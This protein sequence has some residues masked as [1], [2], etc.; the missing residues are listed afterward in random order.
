[1]HN[2]VLNQRGRDYVA[3]AALTVAMLLWGSSFAA[4]KVALEGYQP[5][6][7]TFGRMALGSLTLLPMSVHWKR[8]VEYKRGD[9]KIFLLLVLSEPCLYFLFE[10]YALRYTTASEAGLITALLP[11]LVAVSAWFVFKERLGLLAWIGFFLALAGVIWL[12]LA[13][14]GN[15]ESAAPDS[16]L[17]NSLEF[18]AMVVATLYTLCVRRLANYPAFLIAA[19]QAFGGMCFFGV[20]LFIFPSQLPESF[21]LAPTLATVYLGVVITTGAY[22]LFNVG[23]ARLGAGRGAAWTNLLPVSTLIIS[24][25][26]LGE[27]LAAWQYVAI[28]PILAGVVLSQMTPRQPKRPANVAPERAPTPDPQ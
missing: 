18:M 1:M 12:T 21:P 28:L 20:L 22:G 25:F 2:S 9:W 11:L 27:R 6:V 14:A 5:I 16:L 3:V 8:S 23:V 24:F 10:T 15:E 26:Y 4:I 7:M 17:G 19:V 13:G